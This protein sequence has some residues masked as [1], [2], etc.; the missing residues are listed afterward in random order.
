[1]THDSS[2]MIVKNRMRK[3]VVRY[4]FISEALQSFITYL[5][6][7]AIVFG[8]SK[9][10]II[11]EGTGISSRLLI[12]SPVIPTLVRAVVRRKCMK[13]TPLHSFSDPRAHKARFYVAAKRYCTLFPNIVIDNKN[14]SKYDLPLRTFIK[15]IATLRLRFTLRR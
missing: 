3:I 2:R 14:A 5:I 13:L 1:M 9:I 10:C 12:S 7:S 6:S 11:H 4:K 8:D 15:T